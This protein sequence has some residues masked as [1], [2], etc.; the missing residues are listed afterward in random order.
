MR[1]TPLY[2]D[3]DISTIRFDTLKEEIRKKSF[4]GFMKLTYW[5]AEDYLFYLRGREVAGIRYFSDGTGNR[6]EAEGYKA[7]QERGFLSLYTTSPIEVFA[8]LEC[9]K[10]RISPYNFITYGHELIA[11]IQLSH[12][13]LNKVLENI[14]F[15]QMHGYMIICGEAGLGPFIAFSGGKPVFISG[16]NWSKDATLQVEPSNAY[17]AVFQTEPEFVNFLASLDS[18]KRVGNVKGGNLQDI[19]ELIKKYGTSYLLVEIFL[20]EGMR[21][22]SLMKGNYVIFKALNRL[23]HIEKETDH[24][25]QGAVTFINLYTLEM[26]TDLR[27]INVHFGLSVRETSFVASTTLSSIR[28]AFLEEIGPVGVAVWKKVFEKMGLAPDGL[29]EDK[30]PEFIQRLAEEIPDEKH[31]KRFIEKTMRWLS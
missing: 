28:N 1:G 23:G 29:P 24:L 27:P 17:M 31:S 16:K 20:T 12:A 15:M 8:F 9:L 18:L 11:P 7:Y 2:K 6:I 5:E 10:D 22:F 26:N 25:P 19:K 4:T 14:R 13:D 21:F 3:I 30:L